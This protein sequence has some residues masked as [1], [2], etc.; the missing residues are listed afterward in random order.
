MRSAS[1][2]CRQARSS[3][4]TVVEVLVAAAVIAILAA[5]AYPSYLHAVRKAKR[6]E[7]RTALLQLMQ[8]QER[9]YSQHSSYVAFSALSTD[10]V[11]TRFKWYSGDSP[12][13]SA[14]EIRGAACE[15]ETLRSCLLLTAT[16]G[17][18]RVTRHYTDAE[19][20]ELRLSSTGVK[21]AA[22][23]AQCWQ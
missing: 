15:G 21:T 4:F 23:G 9:H 17:T 22:G 19:C 3:G 18:P 13:K 5:L 1:D 10:P 14:Y 7:A 2:K 8:Q 16:P 20:G 6:A 11:E 12:T